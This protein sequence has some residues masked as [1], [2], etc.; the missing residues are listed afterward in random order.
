MYHGTKP[1][2][3]SVV[4]LPRAAARQALALEASQDLRFKIIG[5]FGS[6]GDA[7]TQTEAHPPDLTICHK[8]IAKLPEFPM[9]K[10]M[11]NMVGSPLV[12]VDDDAN[13]KTVARRIGLPTITAAPVKTPSNTALSAPQR[14][15][16]IGASTGG[17]EALAQLLSVYPVDCPPTVIV[18]HIKPE[19]LAGVVDR[20][21]RVCPAKVMAGS[22]RLPLRPGQVVFAP[23]LPQHLEIQ[24]RT[25]RC[26]MRDLPPVSGHRPSVD[27]LFQS[28]TALKDEAVGV[29]LTGMGRDGA[30]GLGAMRRAGAWTI[31][32]DAATSVVNG[33]PRVATEEGAVCE[34]L[35]LHKISKAIVAAAALK[36]GQ[37]M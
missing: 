23:G 18:Q 35:P 4:I 36:P 27:V 13:L 29:L 20:L 28:V 30:T 34:V 11:L 33:M 26:M 14:V 32:Q 10:A 5:D 19:Y 37:S 15:V 12:T 25:L 17:I 22:S 3:R 2:L 6:L 8:S 1:P 21:D 16:A 9:F 24:P 31:A 7:Y